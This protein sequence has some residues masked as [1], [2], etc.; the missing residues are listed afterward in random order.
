M[1]IRLI[2]YANEETGTIK[3]QAAEAYQETC[4]TSMMKQFYENK[5]VTALTIFAKALHYKFLTR[6]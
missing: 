1:F 6:F 2:K 5:T 3:K 4:K